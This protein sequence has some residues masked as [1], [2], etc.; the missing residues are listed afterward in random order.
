MKKAFRFLPSIVFIVFIFVMTILFFALPKKEYSSSEK[1][2]LAQ[3]PTLTVDSF[4]SGEFGEDFETYLS[5]HTA[6]RNFWVG[7]NSYYNLALGNPLSNGIYHCDDGYLINDPPVTDRLSINIDVIAEF[8]KSNNLDTTMI[9]APS[10]GYISNDVLPNKHIIYNDD[11]LFTET[12]QTL[13]DNNISFVDIKDDFKTAYNNGTQ[14]YYKTDHHWTE[15]GAYLAY[16]ALAKDMNF[17][18]NSK[19]SYEITSHPDFYG[20]TYSSSGF[21]YTKPDDI[22]IWESKSIKDGDITVSITDNGETITHNSLFFLD[23]LNDDDKYP[24]YLDGNHPY[25]HIKNNAVKNGEKLLVIKDSFAHSLVPFL[26]DHY[27]EIFM[28]DMRYYKQSV[29]ELIKNNDFSQLLFI[30]SVDNLGSDTD[31]AWLE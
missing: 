28:I 15:E 25:T 19:E 12:A 20:T 7:F 2:Y 11:E 9:L 24:V 21:W 3:F 13:S 30:Y 26:A 10:T 4:F 31:I 27:S 5:D 14:I 18:A 1:R 22:E 6:F 16:C 8:S 23:N 29:S 17:T